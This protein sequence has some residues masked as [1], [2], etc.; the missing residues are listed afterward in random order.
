MEADT[1]RQKDMRYAMKMETIIM[2]LIHSVF[3]EIRL[4]EN[5]NQSDEVAGV[6]PKIL[7]MCP[8]S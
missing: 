2:F 5:K 7:T 6:L 3:K 1:Y 4:K 8:K